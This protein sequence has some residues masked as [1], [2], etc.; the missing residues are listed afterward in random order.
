V[1]IFLCALL[2][3]FA[4]ASASATELRIVSADFDPYT[5]IV[6][7]GKGAG[8]MYEIVQEL[9][10]RV[11]QSPTI[12]FL[13][14]PRAQELAQTQSDIAI[15]PL[16]R[17]SERE[18]KYTWI[19]HILSDPYVFF[20][21]KKTKFDISKLESMKKLRIGTFSGSLAET[22]LRINGL[23][24][25]NGVATDAQNVS[26]LKLGRIDVWV[27]PL[28]FRYRYKDKG[29]LSSSDLRVGATLSVLEEYLGAS[30]NLD[31]AT[32]KKWQNAF[33]EMKRD[34]SYARIMKKF[35]LKPLK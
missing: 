6:K 23:H 14:W 17:N 30:K 16:A 3:S 2:L 27:A 34:G 18:N 8:A 22:L 12:E 29:G 25:F 1:I 33:V 7:D 31:Q 32:V 21:T 11:G 24:N 5:Y 10:T 28:S 15:I 13:P 19:L 26:L 9:A 4:S 20:A 35:N